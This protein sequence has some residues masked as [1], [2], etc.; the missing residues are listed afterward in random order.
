MTNN[1]IGLMAGKRR[2]QPGWQFL[3]VSGTGI[4]RPAL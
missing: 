4:S 3:S 1:A 2:G